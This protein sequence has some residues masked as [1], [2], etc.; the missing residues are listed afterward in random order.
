[1]YTVVQYSY[2][3]SPT[4]S[5]NLLTLSHINCISDISETYLK[6]KCDSTVYR[7]RT[8]YC[9]MIAYDIKPS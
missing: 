3:N 5:P 4:K 6:M 1:M 7:V 2:C 8:F 9:I